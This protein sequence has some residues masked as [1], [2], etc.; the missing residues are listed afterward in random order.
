MLRDS[1]LYM[2]KSASPGRVAIEWPPVGKQHYLSQNHDTVQLRQSARAHGA[3]K[4]YVSWPLKTS[5]GLLMVYTVTLTFLY[6]F[7]IKLSVLCLCFIRS[8]GKALPVV[9]STHADLTCR[10]NVQRI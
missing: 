6:G 7:P 5:E 1:V 9:L 2:R 10:F 4:K 3:V 8:M